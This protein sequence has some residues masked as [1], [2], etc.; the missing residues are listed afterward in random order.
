MRRVIVLGGTG[1]F[2]GIIVALLRERGM[3]PVAASRSAGA[4]L[5]L[6]A[7]DPGSL[8]EVLRPQDVIVDAA[9]PFQ[10]RTAA[11]LDAVI[12]RGCDVIDI[13]DSLRYTRL[14]HARADAIS[15]A[16]IAVLTSCSSISTVLAA[17]VTASGIADPAIIRG[18]IRPAS[19]ET[20]HAATVRAFLASIGRPIETFDNGQLRGATGWRRSRTFPASGAR[21][22]LVESAAALTLPRA[23][24]NLRAVE[25]FVDPNL[26]RAIAVGL[27]AAARAAWLRRATLRMLPAL[28]AVGRLLGSPHGAFAVEIEGGGEAITRIL[29][30]SRGSYLTAVLPAVIAASRLAADR[31]PHAGVVGADRQVDPDELFAELHRFGIT[32]RTASRPIP[33]VARSSPPRR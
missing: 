16:G 15:G 9:G 24:P 3:E 23:W 1:F 12:E 8:R 19:R 27:D 14:V 32:S 31:F 17:T 10:Q 25:I 11:L 7:E 33:R 18:F 26:P 5:R 28:L 4:A 22:G 30:A 13:S 2:G 21:S 29:S 6:D 20:S